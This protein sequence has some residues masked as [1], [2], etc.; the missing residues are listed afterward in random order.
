MKSAPWILCCILFAVILY[1]QMCQ[2]KPAT[3]SKSDYE[4]LK[5]ASE[6]TV[7][8]YEEILKADSAA[9]E[10]AIAHAEQSAQQARDSE[11]KLSESQAIIS[12]QQAKIEA[13]RKE[14]AD[15]SFIA[16]SPRYIDGCDS[17]ALISGA[18]DLLI[19]KYKIDNAELAAAKEQQIVARDKKL[20]DQHAFNL[21]LRSQL[22][23]CRVKIKEKEE[24]RIKN[25]WYGIIGLTGNKLNPLGGG[26]AG[27]TLINKKG[28]LYGVKGELLA[29]QLW[30]G[31]RTGIQLFK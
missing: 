22:D 19:N 4:A 20:Q 14:R 11:D 3:V 27:I 15:S 10:L 5:K 6:D 25:Q 31:V 26:E 2:T 21:S 17:L 12:R 13:G 7:K 29:G 1:L 30:V 18:Q 16:V 24:M 9:I 28:V 23:S 8:Y